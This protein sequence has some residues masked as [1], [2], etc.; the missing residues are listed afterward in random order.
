MDPVA[1]G[2]IT[3]SDVLARHARVRP[4]NLAFVD[5]RRRCTYS[6]LNQRVIRLAN[7]LSAS[8]VR[9]GDRVA[10][11]GLNCLELIEAWFATLRLGAVAVPVN[12]RLVSEEIAYVLADS[13]VVAVVV[14]LACAPAVA[15]ARTKTPSIRTVLTIGDGLDELIAAA[16]GLALDVT[17]ADEAP[18]FIMYTSGTTGFPKGAVITHRNLYLHAMSVIATLGLRS[19]DNCWMAHAPLF[20]VAGVS[21]MFP[22]FLTGGTVVVPPSGGFDPVAAMRTIVGERVTSCWMTPAQ[23]QTVCALPGLRSWDLS[24]LRRVWW[25]AAP[26]S[27]ALLRTMFDAFPHTEIIAAFGQTECSPITCLLRGQDALRK[28]GSVGTPML[29]VEVRIVDDQM[30]DVPQGEIG[31]IVYRGPLV[32]K[33]YWNKPAETAEAFRGGWF[34]SGDLVPQ[35]A[36]GYIYVVDRKKDMIISG[37]ENIYSAEVENVVAAHAK[38]A[39]V[40]VIGVPDAKWGE[41]PMAVIVARD[42][43]DPPTDDEIDTHCREHLASYKRPRR[44]VV[45]DALPRNA[46]GKVL[47][48]DLRRE[49]AR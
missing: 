38:V 47:K 34:H 12:F 6:E 22:T 43:A 30:D 1:G 35:D 26:A 16:D 13:G 23:W 32:M 27:T 7:V 33:E 37:G 5:Q 39:E 36:D 28:I 19:D 4:G 41:T 17:V 21:G 20:H 45:V 3:F 42:P 8:G 48:T 29:G 14:D 10:V 24:R 46:S 31:E 11:V 2:G 49:Y 40:S 25:G 18:A 44:V 15:R 9:P